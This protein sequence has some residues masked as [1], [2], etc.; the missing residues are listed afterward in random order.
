MCHVFCLYWYGSATD[1]ETSVSHNSSFLILHKN[2][3]NMTTCLEGQI[4]LVIRWSI[5]TGLIVTGNFNKVIILYMIKLHAPEYP[6]NRI[7]LISC[8][9]RLTY[10]KKSQVWKGNGS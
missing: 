4:L 1:L 2:L 3:L 9:E 5:K 6:S 7:F 10:E 8:Q